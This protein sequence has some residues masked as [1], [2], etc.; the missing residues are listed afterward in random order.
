MENILSKEKHERLPVKITHEGS[1]QLLGV[2]EIDDG[3]GYSIASVCWKSGSKQTM[4][5]LA[6]TTPP[7]QTLDVGKVQQFIWNKCLVEVC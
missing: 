4:Y 7:V 1:D 2:P 6:A 5:R 3:T